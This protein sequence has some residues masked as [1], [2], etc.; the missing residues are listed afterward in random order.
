MRAGPGPGGSETDSQGVCVEAPLSTSLQGKMHNFK[1]R[2]D[3]QRTRA[4]EN[5]PGPRCR[6]GPETSA[7]S[8]VP[9]SDRKSKES[10][11]T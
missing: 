11:E 6:A 3:D 10:G 5:V 7:R 1:L 8:S 4:G 2:D 9:P